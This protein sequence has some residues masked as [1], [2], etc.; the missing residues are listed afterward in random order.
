MMWPVDSDGACCSKYSGINDQDIS[1][2]A[3]D[4]ILK[5]KTI[6]VYKIHESVGTSTVR[7][8]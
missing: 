5:I 8:Y 2:D 4:G 7:H 6:A 3:D 1:G